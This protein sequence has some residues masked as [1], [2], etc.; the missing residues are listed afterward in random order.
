MLQPPI[1][2][3]FG[4]MSEE[5]FRAE[6][7]AIARAQCEAIGYPLSARLEALSSRFIGGELSEDEF[8]F[9]IIRP[10]LNS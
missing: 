6:V 2:P 4:S 7:V 5:D 3:D 10:Y 9:E 8:K 1:D